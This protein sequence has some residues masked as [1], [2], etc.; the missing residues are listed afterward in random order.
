MRNNM[1]LQSTFQVDLNNSNIHIICHLKE[2]SNLLEYHQTN[3]LSDLE[4]YYLL[5]VSVNMFTTKL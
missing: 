4:K 2:N 5:F 3:K 1:A